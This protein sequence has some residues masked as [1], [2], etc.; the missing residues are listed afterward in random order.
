M[1][2]VVP[3]AQAGLSV[4]QEQVNAALARL[5]GTGGGL[6]EEAMRYAAL[7][8]GQRIRPL[9]SLRVARMLA[10]EHLLT[11]RAAISVEL[12]HA[13]SLVVDDLP[14]MDD[15]AM[16]RNRPA[17]HRVYGEAVAVLASF[18]LVALAAR[19]VI[20][21]DAPEWAM[22]RLLDFERRLLGTLDPSALIAGQALDLGLGEDPRQPGPEA[23]AALKTAPLFELA[24][25]A[26]LL[27][28]G[29]DAG[30][31]HNLVRFGR[32][33]GVAF[34]LADDFLDGD[35]P[36]AGPALARLEKARERL[37]PYGTA[38]QGLTE[39]LDYIDAR[40]FENDR[41]RW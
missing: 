31:V 17:A 10:A 29:A 5:L 41:R 12:V 28:S 33:F 19:S 30:E 7:G 4:D 8:E 35:L 37:R 1:A 26:G 2:T 24:T 36:D 34:Q 23:V 16:R 11:L 6:V 3:V 39:L 22:S 32:D 21:E 27:F 25:R 20:R 18:A 13:A 15:A 14:C 40:I 9:L 38:A